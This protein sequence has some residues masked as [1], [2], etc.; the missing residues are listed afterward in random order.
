MSDMS[1][2]FPRLLIA[3]EFPP[4]ASG[5]GPAVVRQL[6]KGWPSEKLAWWS[7]L[8]GDQ[9]SIEIQVETHRVARIPRK[10]YPH[11]RLVGPKTWVLKN[12]WAPWAAA[13]LRATIRKNRSDVIWTIP[14]QWSIPPLAN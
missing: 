6:L 1:R 10:L 12:V 2:R 8:P 11:L 9:R 13:H 4:N 7:C 5:G 14:Q 3:T